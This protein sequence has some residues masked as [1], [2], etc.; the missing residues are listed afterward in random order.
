MKE[1]ITSHIVKGAIISL[2]LILINLTGQVTKWAYQS[3]F[4]WIE[5]ILFLIGIL[6]AT[7]YYGK[8]M[9]NQVTFDQLLTHGFKTSSVVICFVFVYSFL[10][11]Y[12]LFPGFVENKM[13]LDLVQVRLLGKSDLEIKQYLANVKKIILA[14]DLMLNL[15]TGAAGS[16]LGSLLI[17]KSAKSNLSTINK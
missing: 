11:L 12:V 6:I 8:Q 7:L 16:L 10:S 1:K 17:K 14:K 9:N 2:L 5:I 3:W 4:G 15:I 13:R